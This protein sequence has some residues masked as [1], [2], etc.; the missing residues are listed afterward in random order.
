MVEYEI[1][2]STEAMQR[3]L[4]LVDWEALSMPQKWIIS[5]IVNNNLSRRQIAAAWNAKFS[6]NI[7]LEAIG[8]RNKSCCI[9]QGVDEGNVWWQSDIFVPPRH[10]AAGAGD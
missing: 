9:I 1:I 10:E 7:R 4:D 2:V 5:Q 6:E 8:K 3:I